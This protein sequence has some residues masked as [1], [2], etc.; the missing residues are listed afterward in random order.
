MTNKIICGIY[1][2]TSP[3]GKIY[4]GQ[5]ENIYRRWRL[6]N[7]KYVLS[8]KSYKGSYPQHLLNSLRKYGSEP[9]QFEIIEVCEYGKLN[10]R[11]M[12]WIEVFD[13]YK[14]PHGMNCTKGGDGVRGYEWSLEARLK[15]SLVHKGKKPWNTGKKLTIEHIEKSVKGVKDAWKRRKESEEYYSEEQRKRRSGKRPLQGEAN[16]RRWEKRKQE[17]SFYSLEEIEKRSIAAKLR[18]QKKREKGIKKSEETLKRHSEASKKMWEKKRVEGKNKFTGVALENIR[19]GHK[20]A[21]ER[22]MNSPDYEEKRIKVNEK[23]KKSWGRRKEDPNYNSEKEKS[24]RSERGKRTEA[25][26]KSNGYSITEETRL[27]MRVAAKERVA[28]IKKGSNGR[29]LKNIL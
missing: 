21:W 11:E 22:M 6:Y 18:E 5:S 29:F 16:K 1:K 24:K 4:I 20:V 10:E 12:Y 27:K 25:T 7:S 28:K 19:N 2:V 13:T 14:T 17:A 3:S 8:C 9:H 26:K 15:Q 23:I